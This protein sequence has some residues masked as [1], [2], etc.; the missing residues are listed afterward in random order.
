MD[1]AG[2]ALSGM[3]MSAG[4]S[5]IGAA[6]SRSNAKALYNGVLKGNE[7]E[8]VKQGLSMPED[9]QAHKLAVSLQ[10]AIDSGKDISGVKVGKL[11]Q[12]NMNQTRKQAIADI[13][14]ELSSEPDRENL[15]QVIEK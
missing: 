6:R 12:E 7:A 15:T 13:T 1:F 3:I 4:A 8:V 9:S 14:E 11:Y 5:G 2:G 10:E